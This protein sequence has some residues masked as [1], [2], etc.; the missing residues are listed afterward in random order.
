MEAILALCESLATGG[1]GARQGASEAR[2][3]TSRAVENAAPGK[4]RSSAAA[5]HIVK[6]DEGRRRL[7][8]KLETR[9]Q[10]QLYLGLDC[11]KVVRRRVRMALGLTPQH[12]ADAVI[13]AQ[14]AGSGV[15]RSTGAWVECRLQ[16]SV[17]R[18]FPAGSRVAAR[19]AKRAQG[20][21][22][23]QLFP[24]KEGRR[25]G[26]KRVRS[27][28]ACT[29]NTCVTSSA[30]SQGL[31]SIRRK[32]PWAGCMAAL[33]KPLCCVSWRGGGPRGLHRKVKHART[34]ERERMELL[35]KRR[36]ATEGVRGHVVLVRL[37]QPRG[38]EGQRP[39]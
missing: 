26:A 38:A 17:R 10:A 8:P 20:R 4:R 5:R 27:L 2:S 33:N 31:A 35:R 18:I 9:R 37:S 14:A 25:A 1:S 11:R 28:D 12:I 32:A 34:G 7:C 39:L 36:P 15:E 22:T 13:A 16:R 23:Q 29:N 3:S 21:S 30:K 24:D 6:N 19:R